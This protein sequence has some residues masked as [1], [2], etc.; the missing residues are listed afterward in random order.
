VK[1]SP[2]A[3]STRAAISGGA[4]AAAAV[5]PGKT[6][7]R[8]RAERLERGPTCSRRGCAGEFERKRA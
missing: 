3:G 6:L 5:A 2:A 4:C 1:A 8:L 7:A